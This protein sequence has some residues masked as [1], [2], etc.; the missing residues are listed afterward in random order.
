[1]GNSVYKAERGC[2]CRLWVCRPWPFGRR[3]R[4][5]EVSL[6]GSPRHLSSILSFRPLL[7]LTLSHHFPSSTFAIPYVPASAARLWGHA[8]RLD[9]LCWA[10]PASILPS[11]HHD[12]HQNSGIPLLSPDSAVGSSFKLSPPWKD[13]LR[14]LLYHPAGL[15][16]SHPLVTP[17][18]I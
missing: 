7:L 9:S 6:H 3:K 11:S 5:L 4:G 13:V 10:F 1:M 18:H 2:F 12:G 16:D 15:E 8:P 14:L 17:L